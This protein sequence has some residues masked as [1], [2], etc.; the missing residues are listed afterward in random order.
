LPHDEFELFAICAERLF[1]LQLFSVGKNGHLARLPVFRVSTFMEA[2]LHTSGRWFRRAGLIPTDSEARTGAAPPSFE[3]HLSAA[4]G[5]DRSEANGPRLTEFIPIFLVALPAIG[6]LAFGA[7]WWHNTAEYES[8]LRE[9][10]LAQRAAQQQIAFLQ[11]EV[12]LAAKESEHIIPSP[13]LTAVD[14][15]L[16]VTWAALWGMH[17]FI[18]MVLAK[19]THAPCPPITRA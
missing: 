11:R 9:A 17:L 19:R 8:L 18:D 14:E 4:R 5:T 12:D 15:V 2:W 1:V 6:A 10:D 3:A 13:F 7:H 16:R